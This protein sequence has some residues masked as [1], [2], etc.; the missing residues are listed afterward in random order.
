[1]I[2][3]IYRVMVVEDEERIL[4]NIIRKIDESNLGFKVVGK[5]L[6]GKQ[7]L[8]LADEL[9]PDVIFTDIKMPVMDGLELIEHLY[10]R[11]PYVKVVI[12]SGYADFEY[13]QKAIIYDV[14]GYLLKPIDNEALM[15][16]LRKLKIMLDS[17]KKLYRERFL[18]PK[19]PLTQEEIVFLVRE[20]IKENYTENINLNFIA[21]RFNYSVSYLSRIFSQYTG[22]SPY[23]YLIELRINRAKHLLQNHRELSI[24]QIGELVGYPD[25]GYFSRI[26][27]RFT[28]KSPQ[29]F[30]GE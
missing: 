22:I 14:K 17:E 1:M 10:F 5:A 21:E 16:I 6:T 27:K 12:I 9:T 28:G 8:T 4:N 29:E 23:R 20:F 7:A 26:F 24:K 30:R 11:Y 13:A 19:E 2:E 18:L 3:C 25:Q 15:E